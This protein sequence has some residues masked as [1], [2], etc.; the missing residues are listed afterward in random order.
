MLDIRAFE[1]IAKQLRLERAR[2]AQLELDVAEL[3]EEIRELLD[4]IAGLRA[5]ENA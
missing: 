4:E 2:R 3:R 1:H 5:L